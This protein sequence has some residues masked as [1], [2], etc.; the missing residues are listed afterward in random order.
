M[1]ELSRL[2]AIVA[3]NRQSPS[4]PSLPA[5]EGP[6]Q[7]GRALTC[8][9]TAPQGR[10]LV[11][12]D[13]SPMAVQCQSPMAVQGQPTPHRR[14]PAC[15]LRLRAGLAAVELPCAAPELDEPPAGALGE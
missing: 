9:I 12:Q 5:D 8:F 7:L 3:A 1:G 14:Q 2:G 4:A 10:G 15:R 6:Q 13:F 11:R